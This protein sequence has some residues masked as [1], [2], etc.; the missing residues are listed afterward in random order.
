MVQNFP[1]QKHN[2]V[3]MG[4]CFLKTRTHNALTKHFIPRKQI[5]STSKAE[6]VNEKNETQYFLH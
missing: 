4:T 3:S 6:K 1:F 2:R 5:C